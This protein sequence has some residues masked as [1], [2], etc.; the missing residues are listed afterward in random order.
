MCLWDDKKGVEKLMKDCLVF[1]DGFLMED[2]FDKMKVFYEL[3]MCEYCVSILD[4]FR[5]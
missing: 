5:K 3:G 2:S 4:K 1:I